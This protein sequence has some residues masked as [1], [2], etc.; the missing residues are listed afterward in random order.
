M[1][2]DVCLWGLHK[3]R[4]TF[5]I[6]DNV[7]RKLIAWQAPSW[8]GWLALP[9]SQAPSIY[10]LKS[11]WRRD[12]Q[13]SSIDLSNSDSGLTKSR[14]YISYRY[15]ATDKRLTWPVTSWDFKKSTTSMWNGLKIVLSPDNVP[16]VIRHKTN[17]L[18]ISRRL[19]D[20]GLGRARRQSISIIYIYV[21]FPGPVSNC[22][23]REI[24]RS[25]LKKWDFGLWFMDLGW[26]RVIGPLTLTQTL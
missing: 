16:E 15:R 12:L 6:L 24:W 18:V 19:I 14:I 21:Y 10:L 7:A 22:D 11:I 17:P 26:L 9:H 13:I 23:R 25:K 20:Q 4:A 8:C 5:Q 2:E 1:H 3:P